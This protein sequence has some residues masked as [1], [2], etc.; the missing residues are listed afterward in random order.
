M[1]EPTH[2]MLAGPLAPPMLSRQRGGHAAHALALHAVAVQVVA[3][4]LPSLRQAR[5]DGSA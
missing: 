4:R 1:R 2:A 5:R 3:V